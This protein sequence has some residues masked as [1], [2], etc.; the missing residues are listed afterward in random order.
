[1]ARHYTKPVVRS[2]AGDSTGATHSAEM[3]ARDAVAASGGLETTGCTDGAEAG[4][5]DGIGDYSVPSRLAEIEAGLAALDGESAMLL[6]DVK[7][8]R[9]EMRALS[10]SIDSAS[11]RADAAIGLASDRA[12]M[13][14]L[15]RTDEKS[16][17]AERVAETAMI[18]AAMA[19]VLAAIAIWR[20]MA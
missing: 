5:S 11:E 9:L 10:H 6:E 19:L 18:V 14:E 3:P 4:F 17:R 13:R 8:T 16:T 15:A 2:V 20:V 1:M 7:T 12:T